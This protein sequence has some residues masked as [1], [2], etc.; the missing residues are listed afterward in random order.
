[1]HH[2]MVCVDQWF[3]ILIPKEEGEGG[4]NIISVSLVVVHVPFVLVIS[5]HSIFRLYGSIHC[6]TIVS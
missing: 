4:G 5:I 3:C 2:V 6:V 1:M